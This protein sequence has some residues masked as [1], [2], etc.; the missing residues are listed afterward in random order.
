MG[1]VVST[2][3]FGCLYLASDLGF[4]SLITT[5]ILLHHTSSR[6]PNKIV[7]CGGHEVQ[8]VGVLSEQGRNLA[9]LR[10]Q[11]S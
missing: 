4:N 9:L 11:T 3:L 6:I 5:T 1:S 7:N 8:R 10:T 2:A